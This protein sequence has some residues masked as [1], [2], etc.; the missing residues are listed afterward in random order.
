MRK[1]E[2]ACHESEKSLTFRSRKAT[3][4]GMGFLDPFP[5]LTRWHVFFCLLRTA[6]RFQARGLLYR[7]RSQSWPEA[8]Q[9][10]APLD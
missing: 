5:P 7:R 2:C 4:P 3:G 8:V 1:T 10:W 6:Q 9:V